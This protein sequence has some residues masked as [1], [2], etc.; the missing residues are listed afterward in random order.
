M[1]LFGEPAIDPL[2][3]LLGSTNYDVAYRA[4][5]ALI[6]IGEAAIQ[7]LELLLLTADGWEREMA[8]I[9]LESIRKS[10]H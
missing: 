2:I 10:D 3:E 5:I 7:P 6:A 9:A 1:A 4:A 8:A